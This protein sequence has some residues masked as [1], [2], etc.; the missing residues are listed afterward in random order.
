ML[1]IY[2]LIF[3]ARVPTLHATDDRL[4]HGDSNHLYNSKTRFPESSQNNHW[5]TPAASDR[6]PFLDFGRWIFWFPLLFVLFW[7]DSG[8]PYYFPNLV[9]FRLRSARLI[10]SPPLS[11]FVWCSVMLLSLTRRLAPSLL[12]DRFDQS[13]NPS[14]DFLVDLSPSISG[15]GC[16]FRDQLRSFCF[17]RLQLV[18]VQYD[19]FE[20]MAGQQREPSNDGFGIGSALLPPPPPL[21][22]RW[23]GSCAATQ[24]GRQGLW[25]VMCW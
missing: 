17:L 7:E 11:Q 6:R 3:P 25:Y 15:F 13:R 20:S 8:S 2:R 21:A 22:G 18:A 14:S 10:Y 23:L 19:W 16:C 9:K 24:E 1:L 4:R 5:I 12:F